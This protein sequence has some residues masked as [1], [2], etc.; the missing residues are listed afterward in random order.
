MTEIMLESKLLSLNEEKSC[1]II[2]GDNGKRKELKQ[3][4]ERNPLTINGKRMKEVEV[5]KFLGDYITN[6]PEESVNHTVKKRIGIAKQAV[7]EIRTI[8]EDRR[9]NAIGGI[10][11]A[12][13]IFNASVVSMVIHNCESWDMVPKKTLK[14]LNDLFLLFF[15]VIFR[16]GTG[17]PIVNFFWE[18]GMMKP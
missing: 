7:Y 15:R 5:I 9:A 12:F 10:N 1:F 16:I 18:T 11:L 2:L 8:I 17:T 13:N 4:V 6:S 14:M 3:E